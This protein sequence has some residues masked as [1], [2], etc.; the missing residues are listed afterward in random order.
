MAESM[1]CGT[2]VIA[3]REGAAPEVIADGVT[4][5]VRDSVDEAVEALRHVDEIDPA[6]CRA[7]VAERFS[8]EGNVARH[9]ALYLKLLGG[10]TGEPSAAAP[11]AIA[12]ARSAP[13]IAAASAN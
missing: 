4:G 11:P 9:E 12:A 3:F 1:A 7:R 6:R 8:A 5:F 2:P 10:A 13:A